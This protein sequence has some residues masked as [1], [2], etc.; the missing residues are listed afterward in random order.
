MGPLY[1]VG[2]AGAWRDARKADARIGLIATDKFGLRHMQFKCRTPTVTGVLRG[3]P[4]FLAA[5]GVDIEGLRPPLDHLAVDRHALDCLE[6]G[7]L[8]HR[9]KQNRLHD[10][11]QAARSVLASD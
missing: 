1:S 11:S 4:G 5:I 9:I 8:E 3:R 6:A 7:Q 2:R 10:R